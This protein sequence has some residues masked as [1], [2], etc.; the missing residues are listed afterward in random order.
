MKQKKGFY[1]M[2]IKGK[3]N[4][5]LMV[6]LLVI[7]IALLI[8]LSMSFLRKKSVVSVSENTEVADVKERV[9]AVLSAEEP[10]E[11]PKEELPLQENS[12]DVKPLAISVQESSSEYQQAKAMIDCL[13]YQGAIELLRNKGLAIETQGDSAVL[14]A[15]LY[16]QCHQLTEASAYLSEVMTYHTAAQIKL[17]GLLGETYFRQ[18]D[19]QSV[20]SLLSQRSPSL[21]EYPSYYTLLAQA[22]LNVGEPQAAL[23]ILQQVVAIY[24][25]NGSYWVALA[26]AY[27]K[28]GDHDSAVVAYN[29][30]AE[31]TDDN[32]Q[33]LLFIHQQLRF[34][35]S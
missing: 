26:F 5:W 25:S 14:L 1:T 2:I 28:A 34:L 22:H 8:P 35:Q 29:K 11:E 12:M 32:P 33:A 3:K 16:L 9:E 15:T 31:L 20:I 19:Y 18:G 6:L 4:K 21:S 13:D 17:V 7:L 10:K 23:E 27:Q 30:A 24:P